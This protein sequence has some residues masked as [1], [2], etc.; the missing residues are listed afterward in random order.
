VSFELKP[1]EQVDRGLRR[2]ARKELRAARRVLDETHPPTPDG[3]HEARK[4]LKKVSAIAGLIDA[5]GGRGVDAAAKRLR[6]IGRKLSRVR[7]ADAMFEIVTKLH[8]SAPRLM[9]AQS[10]KALRAWLVSQRRAV[11]AAAGKKNRWQR[12]DEDLRALRRKAKSW[13]PSHR[14][15]G[16]LSRGVADSLRCGKKALAKAATRRRADDFHRW[17]KEI[18]RLWYE[19]R[20]IERADARVARDVRALHRAETWLGDD[21]NVVVLC[22][23]LSRNG[24]GPGRSINIERLKAAADLYHD[25]ARRKAIVAVRHIYTRKPGQYLRGLKRTWRAWKHRQRHR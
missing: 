21:H 4:S 7:D 16:A 1:R 6:K 3:I 17:R 10:L 20:L 23:A 15:F 19:L 22:A 8:R 5:D 12:L 14:A 13:Q 24:S 9:D 18:K 11:L 2:L 25:R